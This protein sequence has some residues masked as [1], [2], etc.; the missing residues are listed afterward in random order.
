MQNAFHREGF[1]Q[2][3]FIPIVIETRRWAGKGRHHIIRGVLMLEWYRGDAVLAFNLLYLR[4]RFTVVDE[5]ED[6]TPVLHLSG[7]HL[8]ILDPLA[9]H[10]EVQL[11]RC[12][13]GPPHEVEDDG[14]V[15]EGRRQQRTGVEK[16][17]CEIEPRVPATVGGVKW[18]ESNNL[19][20]IKLRWN[21]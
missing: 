20:I 3:M 6:Q 16:L 10:L 7:G 1:L 19:A 18:G 11:S 15:G 4:C 9:W 5:S 14:Q 21:N 2:K 12:P 8:G 13:R 17:N